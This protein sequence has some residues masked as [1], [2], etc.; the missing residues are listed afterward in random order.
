MSHRFRR[1][2][3][4]FVW[5]NKYA[6]WILNKLSL[7]SCQL[8]PNSGIV[9]KTSI[10]ENWIVSDVWCHTLGEYTLGLGII[11]HALPPLSNF[12]CLLYV[13]HDCKNFYFNSPHS[14]YTLSQLSQTTLSLFKLKFAEN[15][16]ILFFNNGIFTTIC[17]TN[18]RKTTSSKTRCC[19]NSTNWPWFFFIATI[20]SNP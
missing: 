10:L 3:S 5:L 4:E 9:F 8:V 16:K 14:L 11:F 2:Q 17:S 12:L 19:Y 1:I 7:N 15:P 6:L 20:T 13:C 18:S